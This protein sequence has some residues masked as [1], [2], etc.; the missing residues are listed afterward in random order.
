[1]N[2][3]FTG[4]TYGQIYSYPA[5]RWKKKKRLAFMTADESPPQ[6]DDQETGEAGR[7]TRAQSRLLETGAAGRSHTTPGL[8]LSQNFKLQEI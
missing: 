7:C 5:V 1:M 3:L 4:K 2:D 8:F 6:D